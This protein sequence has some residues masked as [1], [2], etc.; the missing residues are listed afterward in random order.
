MT[1]KTRNIIGWILT[2]L[3]AIVFLGSAYGK[4]TVS[5]DNLK[6]AELMGFSAVGIKLLAILEVCCFIM[7]LIPRTGVLGTLLL[8]AYMGGAIVTHIEHQMPVMLPVIVSCV[9]WITAFI[10]FP[11]LSRRLLGTLHQEE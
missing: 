8:V 2:G 11:E 1:T 4:F 9:L 3:L 7:F 5:G 6:Q 10:R